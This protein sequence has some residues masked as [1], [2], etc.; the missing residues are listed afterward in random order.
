M[1]EKLI[2]FNSDNVLFCK[3]NFERYVCT[4][5]YILKY[6]MHVKKLNIKGIENTKKYYKCFN[7]AL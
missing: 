2:E 4:F 1:N 6:F 3:H 7:L 5:Y